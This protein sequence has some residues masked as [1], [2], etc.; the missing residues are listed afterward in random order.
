MGLIS[1]K[2]LS[3]CCCCC[4]CLLWNRQWP[5][6]MKQVRALLGAK[7]T[8]MYYVSF[9]IRMAFIPLSLLFTPQVNSCSLLIEA[10]HKYRKQT[11]RQPCWYRQNAHSLIRGGENPWITP[12]PCYDKPWSKA[13]GKK[14][15]RDPKRSQWLLAFVWL[16]PG[17][18]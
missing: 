13:Q 10:N 9:I 1:C 16:Q 11:P 4:Y 2:V 8:K 17:S 15:R 5:G 3:I 18:R 7:R 12:L 14:H 6:K